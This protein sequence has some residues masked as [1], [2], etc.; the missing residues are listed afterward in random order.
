MSSY[1]SWG[2]RGQAQGLRRL[3]PHRLSSFFHP[4]RQLGLL[5]T[6]KFPHANSPLLVFQPP[7]SRSSAFSHHLPLLGLLLGLRPC[8]FVA[9]S[10]ATATGVSFLC[11]LHLLLPRFLTLLTP[12]PLP[13]LI[14]CPTQHLC[15]L[16][17]PTQPPPCWRRSFPTAASVGTTAARGHLPTASVLHL[18]LREVTPNTLSHRCC[19]L[20][21]RVPRTVVSFSNSA[22]LSSPSA[23]AQAMAPHILPTTPSRSPRTSACIL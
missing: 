9:S 7:H 3:S 18:L 22:C 2:Q 15:R 10:A 14:P 23:V 1:S 4:P 19:S 20:P 16:A 12:P 11:P 17:S 6:P 13:S 8:C 21:S 5:V